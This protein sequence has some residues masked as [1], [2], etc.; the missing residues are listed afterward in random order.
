MPRRSHACGSAPGTG[1][2]ET[3]ETLNIWSRVQTGFLEASPQ[4]R[5][6]QAGPA[7]KSSPSQLQAEGLGL[8]PWCLTSHL[9]EG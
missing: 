7:R 5:L 1:E 3:R 6:S 9:E 4:A 8:H 2:T